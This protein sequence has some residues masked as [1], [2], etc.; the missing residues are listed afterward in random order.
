[1]QLTRRALVRARDRPSGPCANFNIWSTWSSKLPSHTQLRVGSLEDCEVKTR[2]Y[3][4]Y[5]NLAYQYPVS[6]CQVFQSTIL[7]VCYYLVQIAQ[8]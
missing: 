3:T 8:L 5:A 6:V 1:M 4:N 2:D 7:S